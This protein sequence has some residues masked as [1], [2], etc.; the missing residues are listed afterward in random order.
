MGVP[1]SQ[2]DIVDEVIEQVDLSA[3]QD[4]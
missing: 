2:W 4:V 3:L 1:G